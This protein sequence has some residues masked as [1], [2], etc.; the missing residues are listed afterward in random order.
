MPHYVPRA[1]RGF[2]LIE[3]ALSL[4]IVGLSLGLILKY[5]G[6]MRDTQGRLGVRSQLDIID[7]ALANFVALNKRLPCPARGTLASGAATAGTE[8]LSPGPPPAALP[9]KGL[10]NP[11]TQ[12]N[13]VVPWVTLGLTE[14]DVTDP[15]RGRMTY[16]TDPNLAHGTP[17]VKLMDMSSCDP[18]G[19]A[20]AG[21]GGICQTAVPPCAASGG[22]TSPSNFLAN[23]GLDVWDGVNGAAGWAVRQNNRVS[24]TGAAYV[25]ISHG[26][27]GAGAYN[28]S[29]V[30][31][32][33][34][35][36]AGTNELPNRANQAV[37]L[38]A[39]LATTYRDS[40]INDAAGASH[41]DDYLSHPTV[42]TVLNR[43]KLGPR[44]H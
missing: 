41:F 22:C 14:A 5:T 11:Q 36:A 7:T 34:S 19:T 31:Q 40:T 33:G 38:A 39:V 42:L 35:V 25:V 44:V 9:A 12:V 20:A 8:T 29:G 27:T 26:P 1:S 6:S 10:C 37:P 15:W 23:K 16:R 32:P 17:L 28:G 18:A 43:A 24:G 4:L 30:L 13:G 3:I 2:T 21:A